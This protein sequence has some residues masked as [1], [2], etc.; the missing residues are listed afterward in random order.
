MISATLIVGG[1]LLL[2]VVFVDLVWTTF[3]VSYGSG[4]LTGAV[5]RLGWRLAAPL[6]R[7]QAHGCLSTAGVMTV[8]TTLAAW[9]MLLWV[10]WSLVFL[11][12]SGSVADRV[13]TPVG[14][15]GRV[16]FAGYSVFT[17]GNGEFRPV[18]AGWQILTVLAALSGLTVVSLAIAYL[19]LVTSAAA[20]RD[21]VAVQIS[22]LGETP[23]E[24]VAA[25][26]TSPD[27]SQFEI[28]LQEL[29]APIVELTQRH[30][31]YPVL[32]FFHSRRRRSSPP[33]AIAVLDDA[34]TLLAVGVSPSVRPSGPGVRN[35]RRAIDAYL[36]MVGHRY[37]GDHAQ[38]PP[39]SLGELRQQQVPVRDDDP[40][41]NAMGQLAARRR[42]LHGLVASEGFA[43]PVE[44]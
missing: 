17:L 14:G 7:R 8:L 6:R 18:G 37:G 22:L 16:Y 9:V 44:P 35:V 24:V 23:D 33:A 34:L 36:D 30:L 5:L 42:A 21:A 31:A 26:W 13:G 11:A 29:A 25:W 12:S 19:V 43:D 28:L 38:P 4:P 32:H 2:A 40:F 27:R 1:A 15:W 39:L 10:A 41:D 20:E 3:G